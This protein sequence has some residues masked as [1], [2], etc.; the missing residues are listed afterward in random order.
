[1]E[2][3]ARIVLQEAERMMRDYYVALFAP[4]RSGGLAWSALPDAPVLR[5][6]PPRRPGWLRRGVARAL[7]GTARRLDPHAAHGGPDRAQAQAC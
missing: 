7:F 5:D 6:E 2:P 1:M 4:Q 3:P